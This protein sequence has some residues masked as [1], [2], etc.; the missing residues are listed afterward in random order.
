VILVGM[1]LPRTIGA[2]YVNAFRT[3]FA[4]SRSTSVFRSCRSAG[5]RTN[6]RQMFQAD[7]LHLVAEAQPILMETCGEACLYGDRAA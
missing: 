1:R 6:E 5:R 7:N 3:R 2:Q 4:T